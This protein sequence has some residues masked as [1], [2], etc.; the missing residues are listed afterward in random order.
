MLH[1]SLFYEVVGV[2]ADTIT[3]SLIIAGGG[4]LVVLVWLV[5]VMVVFGVE[6]AVASFGNVLVVVDVVVVVEAVAVG[7]DTA[8][9]ASA[10]G[11]VLELELGLERL[12]LP[13]GVPLAWDVLFRLAFLDLRGV[14]ELPL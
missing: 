14:V 7:A 9:F 13:A 8:F 12:L 10:V 11:V 2:G 5:V 6:V 4:L 3:A 1:L